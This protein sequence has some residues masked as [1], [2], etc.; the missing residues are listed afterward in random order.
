VKKGIV[1]SKINDAPVWEADVES[2]LCKLVITNQKTGGA[3][4]GSNKLCLNNR[5]YEFPLGN[6]PVR[7]EPFYKIA[8]EALYG[9][10]TNR[11]TF[12]QQPVSSHFRYVSTHVWD[13]DKSWKKSC[14][15]GLAR[16]ESMLKYMKTCDGR[17]FKGKKTPNKKMIR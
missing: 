2:W 14:E 13:E 4:C 12:S 10:F 7:F 1:L 6:A 9:L 16:Q 8:E 15:E 5:K 17:S 11:V 3:F